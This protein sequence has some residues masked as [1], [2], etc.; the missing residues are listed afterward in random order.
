MLMYSDGLFVCY[1]KGDHENIQKAV[2]KTD[3]LVGELSIDMFWQ[4][5]M[6]GMANLLA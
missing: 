6:N 2:G 1:V 5:G 4:V 3:S